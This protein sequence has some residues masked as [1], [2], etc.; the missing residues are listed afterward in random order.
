MANKQDREVREALNATP[1]DEQ[2]DYVVV[3]KEGELPYFY[4]VVRKPTPPPANIVDEI[5]AYEGGSMDGDM[6]R[7]LELYRQL[8]ESGMVWSLQGHYQRNA[9]RL[10]VAGVIKVSGGNG[11]PLKCTVDLEECERRIGL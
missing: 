3:R 2:L 6:P 11:Q 8:I 9:E 10:I 7:V 1:D 5:L 4:R